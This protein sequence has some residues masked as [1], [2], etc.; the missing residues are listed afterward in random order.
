MFITSIDIRREG[1]YGA[2]YGRPDPA[3]PFNATI[4]VHGANGKVE[5]KLSPDMSKRIVAIV[6]DEVAAAGRATAEAMTAE[7]LTATALPSKAA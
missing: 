7:C 3:K 6:A 5:L 4:E 2:G 1:Y